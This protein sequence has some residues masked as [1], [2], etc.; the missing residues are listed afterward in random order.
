LADKLSFYREKKLLVNILIPLIVVRLNKIFDKLKVD[1]VWFGG[2]DF[3]AHLLMK[4]SIFPN[5]YDVAITYQPY[6]PFFKEPTGFRDT[7]PN[8]ARSETLL[9]FKKML[10][11][12]VFSFKDSSHKGGWFSHDSTTLF[13]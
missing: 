11:G 8:I 4:P 5:V 12:E 7:L 10:I 1:T 2:P 13:G 3:C 9:S 6:T